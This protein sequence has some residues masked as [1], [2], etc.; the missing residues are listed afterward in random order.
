MSSTQK[1]NTSQPP[2]RPDQP[3][4]VKLADPA[5]YVPCTTEFVNDQAARDYWAD[6]FCDHIET[7]VGLGVEATD[8]PKA[9]ERAD[10]CVA[11]LRQHMRHFQ[12]HPEEYPHATILVLDVWR[13]TFLRKHGFE[14]C[15]AEQKR[16]ENEQM[17]KL[18]PEVVSKL[19]ALDGR[20]KWRR[21]IEGVFAG[22]IFDMGAK[23][24]AGRFRDESPDFFK[25]LDELKPRPWR[26]DDLDA[27]LEQAER[28]WRKAVV[29]VDNAGSDFVLGMVPLIRLLGQAGTQVVIAANERP[30][31]NDMTIAEVRDWWPRLAEAVDLPGD[32]E[33][34][35]SGTGEPLI[36]LRGVSDELNRTA[37]DADLVI[38]EGMG[39][40]VESNLEAEFICDRMNLAMLKDELIAKSLGGDVY[41]CVC[42]FVPAVER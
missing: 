19:D 13:D 28:G 6:F 11:D 12:A 16:R 10:A 17:I 9:R 1:V 37:E 33:L 21:A 24:T 27:V 42:K 34:V 4:F 2:I 20:A 36:D 25:T 31:L 32:V 5:S 39:R 3:A 30:S 26:V 35:S 18:L 29:F 7:I 14:D 22:N 15:F 41:D 23:S 8:D 40:G 38:L